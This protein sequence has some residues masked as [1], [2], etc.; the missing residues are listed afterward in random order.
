MDSAAPFSLRLYHSDRYI[1]VAH[2]GFSMNF[3]NEKKMMLNMF[4]SPSVDICV[5]SMVKNVFLSLVHFP[6]LLHHI[7]ATCY[8]CDL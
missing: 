5:S 8:Q 2:C 3:A 6:I 7:K 1:V 4:L